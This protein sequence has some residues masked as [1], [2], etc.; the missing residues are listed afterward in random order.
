MKHRIAALLAVLP[1]VMFA[2]GVH[3]QPYP[4]KPI[5]LVVPFAAGG[6]A[7]IMARWLGT[8]L[9]AKLGQPVVVDNKGGAGGIIGAQA[10]AT[11][12][13]DGY[14][15]LFSSV[16]AIAI[17]PYI[18]DKVPYDPDKDLIPV[19]RF[20]TA[21][22]VLVTATSSKYTKLS[23][24]VA[25]AKANPG[26]VTFASA[27]VGTTTQLGSELLKREA[28]IDMVHVPYRGAA[29]AITDVMAGTADVMFADAPVVLPYVKSGKLKALTIGTPARATL[30]QDVPTT[31]EAG[32]KGVLVTTWYG[33]LAP[34]K[35]PRDIVTKL[36]ATVNL[37][38]ASPEGKAF[39]A[40]QSLEANGGTPEEFGTFI[41]SEATRWTALAKAAGVKME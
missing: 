19:V 32:Y 24:L 26:K 1:A 41:K 33:V 16:G 35:T 31:A 3:A 11:A 4:S 39:I 9:T 17:A 28:G 38:L 12:P 15:L 14:T 5:R 34:A 29:P 23:D 25:F 2:H 13:P 6:P 40:A 21:P 30:M 8:Q 36:N 18:S 37:I 10:V 20:A 27:G 22:T 7:D